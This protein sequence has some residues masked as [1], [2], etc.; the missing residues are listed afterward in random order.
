[1][2]LLYSSWKVLD[3]SQAYCTTVYPTACLQHSPGCSPGCLAATAFLACRYIAYRTRSCGSCLLCIT[4]TC[5]SAGAMS[6]PC[7]WPMVA[8]H[9]CGMEPLLQNPTR[10]MPPS[11]VKAAALSSASSDIP[12]S[13]ANINRHSDAWGHVWPCLLCYGKKKQTAWQVV[14]VKLVWL[15][16]NE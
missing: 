11:K 7:T 16:L 12:A 3:C 13:V 15:V 5:K 2:A 14:R 6:L 1:M 4:T 10:C 9:S 8:C